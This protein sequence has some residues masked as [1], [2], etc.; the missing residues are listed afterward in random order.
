MS[1]DK[2]NH[3]VASLAF[4]V[5]VVTTVALIAFHPNQL[6][7]RLMLLLASGGSSFIFMDTLLTTLRPT[8]LQSQASSEINRAE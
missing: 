5:M 7:A 6:W 1:L 3:H 4:V 8:T 2:T